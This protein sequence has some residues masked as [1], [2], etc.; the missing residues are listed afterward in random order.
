MVDRMARVIRLDRAIFDDAESSAAG[1]GAAAQVVGIVAFAI[2]IGTGLQI[3]TGGLPR[4]AN[5]TGAMAGSLL[6][7]FVHWLIWSALI[8]AVG[9]IAFQGA[10]TFPATLR[11]IGFAM[12]PLALGIFSFVP[13]VGPV[14]TIG[15]QLLS[16]R[17]GSMAVQSAHR[18]DPRR[19]II[20]IAVTFVVAFVLSNAMR[21]VL[22]QVGF[23]DMFVGPFRP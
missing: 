5:P 18:F 13:I 7:P 6:A 16:L 3:A 20:T 14:I 1:V 11:V 2:T 15:G 12:A 4:S 23:W 17:A 10:A 19:T 21:A 9:G 8:F 22:T